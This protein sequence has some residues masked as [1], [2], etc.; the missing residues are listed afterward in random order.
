MP[1]R[2]GV[3]YIVWGKGANRT[4]DEGLRR[5]LQSVFKH[6]PD[7]GITVRELPA[8]ATLLDKAKMY[9]L[10]PYEE[11]LYLDADTEVLD[12]LDFGFEMAA[13]HGAA[14]SICE[15]PYA[16]R[17]SRSIGGDAVEYNTGVI[18]FVKGPKAEP[19][20]RRWG[21]LAPTLDSSIRWN[22]GMGVQT[23]ACNDQGSFAKAVADTGFNPFVLPCNWNL[24]PGYH[25]LFWG[26]VKVW[27]DYGPVPESLREFNRQQNSPGDVIDMYSLQGYVSPFWK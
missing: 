19:L 6:H 3:I 22:S 23:M 14:L 13:K 2:R 11:T 20:F 25:K 1:Q 9:D 8:G 4:L 21:A 7:W 18:F 12:R 15:C 24:R 17:Y 27:H 26:P 16:R 5:S 10:S